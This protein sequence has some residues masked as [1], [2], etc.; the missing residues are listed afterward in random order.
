[1]TSLR[2]HTILYSIVFAYTQSLIISLYYTCTHNIVTYTHCIYAITQDKRITNSI[3]V[4]ICINNNNVLI[5]FTLFI[6]TSDT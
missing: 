3:R 4:A 2:T 5:L 1:L 6:T